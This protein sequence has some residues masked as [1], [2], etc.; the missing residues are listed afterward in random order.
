M[1]YCCKIKIKTI[2]FTDFLSCPMDRKMKNKLQ[3]E[4][5][6]QVPDNR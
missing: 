5:W 6:F 2:N 4:F 3:S 1:D